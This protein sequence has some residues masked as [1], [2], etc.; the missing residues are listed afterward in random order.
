MNVIFLDRDGTIVKDYPDKVW[1][2]V[3]NLELIPE[4][5]TYLQLKRL[6]GYQFI[7]ITNQYLIG[8]GYIT[9]TRFWT[10][11]HALLLELEE[12]GV[13]IL[14]TLYC[15]HSRLVGCNCCKPKAGMIHQAISKYPQIDLKQAVYVGDSDVDEIIAAKM[16]IQFVRVTRNQFFPIIYYA[17]R[18]S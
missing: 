14:D 16:K 13:N 11:H 2:N 7:F 4:A 3:L 17:N 12:H 18:H 6:E 8:E 1:S 10:L 5:V 9:E 15:P